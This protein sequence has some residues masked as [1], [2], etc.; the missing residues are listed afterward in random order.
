VSGDRK[1][2]TGLLAVNLNPAVDRTVQ[3][4]RLREEDRNPVLAWD[5]EAGGKAANVARTVRDEGVSVVVQA[6]LGGGVGARY[7]ELA[8]AAGLHLRVFP[9]RGET[10]INET[11]LQARNSRQIRLNFPGPRLSRAE[12]AVVRRGVEQAMSGASAV[13]LCGSLPPGIPPGAYAGWIR[14]ARRGG[15]L[16]MLDADGDALSR[17][18]KAGPDWVKPNGYELARCVGTCGVA[19]EKRAPRSWTETLAA[20]RTLQSMGARGVLVSLG[21]RG[22]LLVPASGRA[23]KAVPPRVRPVNTVGA[24]DVLVGVLLAQ[25]LQGSPPEAAL[26]EGV[27]AATASVLGSGTAVYRKADRRRIRREVRV[28]AVDERR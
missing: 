24:G 14:N 27:A 22:A 25:L 15:I 12:W 16:S 3:V 23:V 8:C 10:R 20:V 18:V 2:G 9:I 21:R 1:G 17:G 28:A 19:V 5:E 26:A 13:V 6:P 11:I 4:E 7:E